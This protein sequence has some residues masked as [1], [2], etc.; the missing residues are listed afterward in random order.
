[1]SLPA[2]YRVTHWL[3]TKTSFKTFEI[4]VSSALRP[5]VLL[6]LLIIFLFFIFWVIFRVQNV[7]DFLLLLE[8]LVE[9][10]KL[11]YL[12]DFCELAFSDTF[13]DTISSF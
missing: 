6:W 12:V 9:L 2:I 1:M 3:N 5:L 8:Y 13:D 7:M 10:L 4:L 11:F